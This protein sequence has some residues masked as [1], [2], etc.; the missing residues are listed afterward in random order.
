MST[1]LVLNN[2]SFNKLQREE[3]ERSIKVDDL[4]LHNNT[5]LV[6][7][8]WDWLT[9]DEEES[10]ECDH[11]QGEYDTDMDNWSD[12]AD[13]A[14]T[15]NTEPTDKAAQTH[16]IT[17]SVIFKCIGAN[18]DEKYQETLCLASR[19]IKEVQVKLT[20][21]EDNPKNARAIAFTCKIDG[22]WQRIGY[23]VEEA[24]DA[25]H[26]ALDKESV[27]F[28]WVK[29]LIHWSCPGWYAGINVTKHGQWPLS[30][31][32]SASSRYVN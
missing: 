6:L 21:E 25:V 28:E 12:D 16:H 3:F 14:Q 2:S 20:P 22:E 17:H 27:S 15:G 31:L 29:F 7:W 5:V 9:S 1:V 32:R 10:A 24:L 8:N 18:K 13:E 19:N 30:V 23:V 26:T 11:P 4:N